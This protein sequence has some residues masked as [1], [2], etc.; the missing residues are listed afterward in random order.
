M[1]ILLGKMG[2]APILIKGNS[3]KNGDIDGTCK[4]SLN[5]C[6]C[7][8]RTFNQFSAGVFLGDRGM[9]V[10]QVNTLIGVIT[11][12]EITSGYFFLFLRNND[13]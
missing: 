7:T 3:Y 4:R 9:F 13:D 2:C 12:D 5:V 6:K 8:V 1:G 10:Q 11:A